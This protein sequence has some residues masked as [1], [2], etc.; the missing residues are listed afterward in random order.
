[1]VVL[2]SL[3]LCLDVIVCLFTKE[4]N[5]V[6]MVKRTIWLD[7]FSSVAL[8]NVSQFVRKDSFGLNW[9]LH[10]ANTTKPQNSFEQCSL[11]PGSNILSQFQL[12]VYRSQINKLVTQFAH[13]KLG[14]AALSVRFHWDKSP[15][16]LVLVFSCPVPCP[17]VTCWDN[18]YIAMLTCWDGSPQSNSWGSTYSKQE[19]SSRAK[20]AVKFMKPNFWTLLKMCQL[21]LTEWLLLVIRLNSM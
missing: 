10:Y 13:S 18:V 11:C 12:K 4:F 21:F 8:L 17:I 9:W 7:L 2:I 5:M 6:N 20:T 3:S 14:I 1:M 16:I 15:I 19:T